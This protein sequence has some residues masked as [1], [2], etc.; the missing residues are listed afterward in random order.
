[1]RPKQPLKWSICKLLLATVL[2]VVNGVICLQ[3]VSH[4][5]QI[6]LQ[7]ESK[8]QIIWKFRSAVLCMALPLQSTITRLLLLNLRNAVLTWSPLYQVGTETE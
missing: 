4:I 1:M 6:T 8:T 2:V 7:P 3:Q 5:I